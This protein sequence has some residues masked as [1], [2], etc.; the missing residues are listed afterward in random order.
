M[1]LSVRK[2]EILALLKQ[3]QSISVSELIDHFDA[4]PATIR[5]DLSSL[6]EEN[7]IT[8]TRGEI[9]LPTS[10][11][12]VPAVWTRNTLHN[13]EKRAIAAAAAELVH[14]GSTVLL[15]SGSTS[16]A[17]A[18]RLSDKTF[19]AVTNSL[20]IA[21]AL[22]NTAASVISCGGLLQ[23]QHMCFLG[24][25]AERFI[26]N[27]E[28]DILF[29]GATG[30]RGSAGLTTSSPLQYNLKQSMMKSAKQ[31]YAL[32]DLSK[33]HSANIYMFATFQQI[34]AI[35]TTRPQ[36]GSYEEEQLAQIEA[37]GVNVIYAET[38]VS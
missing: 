2:Q 33:F 30:I 24:P 14:N 16:L 21:S 18:Q 25:D 32:F 17:L 10:T 38:G 12:I 19:T 4:A 26:E 31:I 9:H 1:H 37:Q 28:V 29:L 11:E 3:R 13:A 36:A 22:S 34:D 15:D 6:A 23:S 35:I 20:D 5:R 8:R 7:L 27:I